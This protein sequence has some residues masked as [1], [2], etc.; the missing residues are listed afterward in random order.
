M[1]SKTEA[2]TRRDTL[3]HC[4]PHW[5]DSDLVVRQW[6]GK[7]FRILD[8][9][10]SSSRHG[11]DDIDPE[12]ARRRRMIYFAKNIGV[13]NEMAAKQAKAERPDPF[14]RRRVVAHFLNGVCKDFSDYDVSFKP[15]ERLS[16][17][18]MAYTV[19]VPHSQKR[20]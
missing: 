2:L 17:L 13:V 6:T 3:L 11:F 8:E 5:F 12:T 1:T 9:S 16:S 7:E 18:G 15:E 4:S 14:M 10:D 20:L 19:E